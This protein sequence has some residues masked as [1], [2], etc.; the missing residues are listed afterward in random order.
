MNG[1]TI[2]Y[3]V[4]NFTQNFPIRSTTQKYR[5]LYMKRILEKI[6]IYEIRDIVTCA[7]NISMEQLD[8]R[9][10]CWLRM[11][12]PFASDRG[13]IYSMIVEKAYIYSELNLKQLC[14]Y[15][16]EYSIII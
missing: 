16:W 7:E 11:R 10:I 2:F 14:K 6:I 13:W 9:V 15:K 1:K 12:E 8:K 3:T 5:R 4:I